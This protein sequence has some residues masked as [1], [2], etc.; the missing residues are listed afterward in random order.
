MMLLRFLNSLFSNLQYKVRE[1]VVAESSGILN[2]N[3]NVKAI[4]PFLTYLEGTKRL[5]QVHNIDNAYS[6][7]VFPSQNEQ[8]QPQQRQQQRQ[9]E[10]KVEYIL[11]AEEDWEILRPVPVQKSIDVLRADPNVSVVVL[12]APYP[13]GSDFHH[14]EEWPAG[15][16]AGIGGMGLMKLE[17][18]YGWGHFTWNPG[19]RRVSDFLNITKGSYSRWDGSWKSNQ[20]F[21]D[22]TMKAGVPWVKK[23]F[24]QREFRI[25]WLFRPHRL[26]MFNDSLVDGAYTMHCKDSFTIKEKGFTAFD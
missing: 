5:S 20:E 25:N 16:T 6:H 23:H 1:V 12:C 13:L 9:Q 17:T 8:Q 10:K 18:A 22:E 15:Q 26:A 4:Y 3:A 7:V 2:V 21:K 19:L 14:I 11:H 24:I